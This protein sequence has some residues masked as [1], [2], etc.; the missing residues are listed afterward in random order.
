MKI[1]FDTNVW[2]SAMLWNRSVANK[3]FK[4]L[5]EHEVSIYTS[6]ELLVECKKVLERDF[7]ES[8]MKEI[9]NELLESSVYIQVYDKVDVVANDKSDNIIIECALAASADFIIS[10]DKHLLN[11]VEYRNIRLIT[12]ERAL[13]LLSLF[14]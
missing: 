9:L 7:P 1:V 2:I 3:L 13:R 8:N 14:F 12:P 10:Y 4:L 6:Y 11:I 5:L